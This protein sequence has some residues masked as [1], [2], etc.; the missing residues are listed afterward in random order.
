MELNNLESA[1]DLQELLGTENE[2]TGSISKGVF[3]FRGASQKENETSIDCDTPT[4]RKK[5]SKNRIPKSPRKKC[6]QMQIA[7]DDQVRSR[8]FKLFSAA[9]S[10]QINDSGEQQRFENYVKIEKEATRIMRNLQNINHARIVDQVVEY[11]Q[12]V[13][14]AEK[15][16]SDKKYCQPKE[17]I[18]NG[19]SFRESV[20]P[21]EIP[22]A[23]L[24]TGI[25]VPDHADF[26]QLLTG[27]LKSKRVSPHVASIQAKECG[28]NLRQLMKVII[29][30]LLGIY[31][32]K[33]KDN[34]SDDDTDDE[35]K[36]KPIKGKIRN[37]TRHCGSL[38]SLR[39]WYENQYPSCLT[40]DE[41]PPLIIVL[42]DFE[43]FVPKTLQE[44]I[45]NL[46]LLL[47][48][49]YGVNDVSEGLPFVLIF[50][51]ATTV[52]TIHRTLPHSIT[53]QLA[54]EKFAAEPSTN[55]LA[56]VVENI[57]IKNPAIPFKIGGK[58]LEHLLKTFIFT[59]FSVKHFVMA[60]KCCLLEHYSQ[61]PASILCCETV[62]ETTA[63]IDSMSKRDIN[64]F[65]NLPS[66][67]EMLHSSPKKEPKIEVKEEAEIK[68]EDK[69]DFQRE[70]SQNNFKTDKDF[71]TFIT[72]KIHTLK[73]STETFNI[74]VDALYNITADL[75]NQPLG[76]N[77]HNVYSKAM[78]KSIHQDEYYR[79]AFSYLHLCEKSGMLK[80]LNKFVSCL[81]PFLHNTEANTAVSS[82]KQFIEE[83]EKLDQ[84][85]DSTKIEK[86]EEKKSI[87]SPIL[88]KTP[89]GKLDRSKWQELLREQAKEKEKCRQ[90]LNPFEAIR[91]RVNDFYNSIFTRILSHD[92]KPN[93]PGFYPLNQ[94]FHEVFY[95]VDV[96]SNPFNKRLK[97]TF[98][99]DRLHG[100]P[101]QALKTALLKPHVYLK[102]YPQLNSESKD[103]DVALLPDLCTAYKLYLENSRYINL[104]DWLNCWISLVT[105]G[106]EEFAP[107]SKNKIQ[108]DHKYQARFGRCISELQFLGLIRP[109]KRKIDHVERLSFD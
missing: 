60:Y 68:K 45:R 23:A 53:S 102:S 42:E 25:N 6:K 76:K 14:L 12:K 78:E 65:R 28:T 71:K 58:A 55:L 50:G 57:I 89:K 54:I 2:G 62:E 11:V 22:T 52:D 37:S 99:D 24:L 88:I 30:Q 67:Q 107:N 13:K 87:V 18:E 39:L 79:L 72:N 66:F 91:K 20:Q 26:F 93:L 4:K 10:T 32:A 43:S 5:E 85:N 49:S 103:Y 81:K 101:R 90:Q 59:D 86:S 104:F 9:A 106:A 56:K 105:N 33:Q 63:I 83:L 40:S 97:T 35:E 17:E 74:F 109:S 34:T 69:A 100:A 48:K 19:F 75:P 41:R 7:E 82:A 15:E 92:K 44:L 96:K 64:M 29:K 3:A 98:I 47:D 31:N 94:V 38:A 80:H 27:E 95:F 77:Y 46:S 51:I 16:K 70:V 36:E 108:V 21:S 73:H 61:N 1:F 8:D 84:L